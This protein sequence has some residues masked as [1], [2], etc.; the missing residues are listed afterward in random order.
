MKVQFKSVEEIESFLNITQE[1]T[2]DV[3]IKEGS[4]QL[5]GKSSMGMMKVPFEYPVEV[6]LIEK[7]GVNETSEFIKRCMAIGVC[8]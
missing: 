8:V 5:D 2:S 6:Y 4:L 1:M 7:K 3:I